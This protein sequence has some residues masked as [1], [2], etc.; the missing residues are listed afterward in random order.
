[1]TPHLL[2]ERC[3]VELDVVVVQL[4]E[5]DPNAR[6]CFCREQAEQRATVME[7]PDDGCPCIKGTTMPPRTVF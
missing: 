3:S 2:C 6:C 5:I 7:E 1:M 4:S